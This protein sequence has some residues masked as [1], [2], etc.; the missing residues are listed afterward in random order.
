MTHPLVSAVIPAFNR[1]AFLRE[2]VESVLAQTVKDIEVIV[3]DD[4]S[5]D[6]TAAAVTRDYPPVRLIRQANSGPA[7]AR[8]TGWL[9]SRG[10]WLAFL[11]SDDLWLPRKLERQLAILK[12]YPRYQACYTDEIWIR[13]GVRVNQ[14]KIHRKYSGWIFPRAL[15]LCIISPSSIIMS[16]ALALELTGPEGRGPFREDFPVCEDYELWLRLTARHPVYFLE[17]N[18]IIKRGGHPD[19]LSNASWGNDR[20]RVEALRRL[21]LR[22]DGGLGPKDRELAAREMARKCNILAAGYRK[23]GKA[24]EA[25]RYLRLEQE[26]TE[27]VIPG[28]RP[29]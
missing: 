13:R 22:P 29:G 12:G 20:F 18:L 7:A 3:V 21:L 10:D 28:N 9:A 4:G 23:H 15:P 26:A 19:Q 25:A 6:D 8:N 27:W 17:E 1:L 2:A 24:M 11:D 14:K 16:R 5:T